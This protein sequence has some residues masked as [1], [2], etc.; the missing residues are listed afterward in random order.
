MHA[1]HPIRKSLRVEIFCTYSLVKL[2]VFY[3]SLAPPPFFFFDPQE[4]F[5][6][7]YKPLSPCPSK[8]DVRLMESKIKGAKKCCLFFVRPE[9]A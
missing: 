2:S 7:Q 1:V 3:G 5:A 8:S 9:P 6:E 4:T